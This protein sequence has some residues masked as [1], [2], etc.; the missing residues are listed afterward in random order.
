M[1]QAYNAACQPNFSGNAVPL[2]ACCEA[3]TALAL[4][5]WP[6]QFV[7]GSE[8]AMSAT[9]SM[10][11]VL[12]QPG[13]STCTLKATASATIDSN[14]SDC[15]QLVCKSLCTGL[16]VAGGEQVA[17]HCIRTTQEYPLGFHTQVAGALSSSKAW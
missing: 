14:A 1:M 15:V 4:A 6:E 12:Q 17:D 13:R 5:P 7:V 8:P 10:L 3:C 11:P 9:D 2:P 16:F